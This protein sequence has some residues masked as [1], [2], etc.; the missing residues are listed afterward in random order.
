VLHKH[1]QQ[2]PQLAQLPDNVAGEQF[3]LPHPTSARTQ[4]A[5]QAHA[6]AVAGG[7]KLPAVSCH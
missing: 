3:S 2:L 4:R 7:G 1:L 6:L 5:K